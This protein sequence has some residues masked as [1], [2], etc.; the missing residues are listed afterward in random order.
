MPTLAE[1]LQAK[2]WTAHTPQ[3][4]FTKGDWSLDFDTSHWLIVSSR[5]NPRVFDVPAPDE[6]HAAWAANLV[7]HLCRM[8]DELVR[9]RKALSEIR[10]TSDVGDSAHTTAAK[11][12]GCC[13]HRWLVNMGVSEGRVGRVYCP[14]CGQTEAERYSVRSPGR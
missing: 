13:Y 5:A 4:P 9:L 1:A 7:E 6:Y 14:I 3:E 11:A 8:E 12:L 2:G 10:D